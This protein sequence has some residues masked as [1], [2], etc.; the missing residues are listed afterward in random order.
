MLQAEGTAREIMTVQGAEAR[1]HG[2]SKATEGPSQDPN[3]GR[4]ALSVEP[5]AEPAMD[6]SAFVAK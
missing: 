2:F 6:R 1:L 5:S 4:D 3:T